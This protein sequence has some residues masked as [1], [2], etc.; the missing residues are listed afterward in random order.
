MRASLRDGVAGD[1]P[2]MTDVFVR[3]RAVAMPWLARPHDDAAT[4]RWI[5]Q[6]VLAGPGVTVACDGSRPL[7]FAVVDA[8][9]LEH[10]YVDPGEQGRGIGRSLLEH[11]QRA[12]NGRLALQV[13]TA[14]E[15]ARR[16]YRAAG[17]VLVGESDGSRNEEHEP[18]CTYV[19]AAAGT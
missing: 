11:A 5:E 2:W 17:F 4:R 7:G 14:N 16:F 6:V 10:L 1:A 9:R 15:R 19:W 8:D 18:D 12:S 3:S 13:F